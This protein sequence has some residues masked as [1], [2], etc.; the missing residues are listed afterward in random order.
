MW[1]RNAKNRA[2]FA[3]EHG[4]REAGSAEE[5]MRGANIVVTATWAKDPV[6]E[7]EW[8]GA[9]THVNAMGSN[10][11]GRRELPGELIERADLIAVDALDVAKIESGDLILAGVDWSDPRIVELAQ[12]EGR[13]AGDP[14]TIFKSNGLGVEDVAAAAYVYEKLA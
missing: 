2:R 5:A 3:A 4:V 6:L 9:G 11:A 1:S 7:A 13:P 14:I 12:V 10:Q 8:I